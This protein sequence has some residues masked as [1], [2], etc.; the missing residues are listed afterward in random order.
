MDYYISSENNQ[1][2]KK[3]NEKSKCMRHKII[4]IIITICYFILPPCIENL[5]PDLELVEDYAEIN[6]Y[7]ES[8][9]ET[10]VYVYLTFNRPVD[11]GYA[12]IAF[13]DSSE[14]LLATEREYFYAFN[15]KEA[16]SLIIQIS[17]KVEYY[18]VLSYEFS[19]SS[20]LFLSVHYAFFPFF[21]A[22]LIGA[23]LL[24]YKEYCYNDKIISVYAGFYHHTLR[25]DGELCDEH[26]TIVAYTPI[27]LSTTIGEDVIE[28]TIS[29]TNR[30]SIKVN[31][32]LIQSIKPL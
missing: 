21:I 11:S 29:L 8:L 16:N 19:A 30:I 3:Y 24:S 5:K 31:N 10:S 20:P 25:V 22:M 4:W 13:Y 7:Y 1:N 32:K 2:G 26:N 27:K 28:A 17:G 15:D 6:E 14:N 9:D 18:Q 23:L 12:T